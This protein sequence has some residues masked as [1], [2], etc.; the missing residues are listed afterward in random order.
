VQHWT[1]ALGRVLQAGVG[2]MWDSQAARGEKEGRA[3]ANAAMAQALAADPN[4][5]QA[6]ISAFSGNPW[7]QEMG[8][9]LGGAV[10]KSRFG[11]T[12]KTAKE[13]DF[14]TAKAGGYKGSFVEFLQMDKPGTVVNI[15]NK[16][17]SEEAKA[18]GKGAGEAANKVRDRAD[19]AMTNLQRIGTMTALQG[20]FETGPLAEAKMNV[21]QW[22]K[23]LGVSEATLE[24]WGIGKD[25]VGDA[26][27]FRGQANRGVVDM[28]GAGGFPANN[29]SDADRAFLTTTVPQLANDPRGNK[30]LMEFAK[31]VAHR[32]IEK[33][34]AWT[35]FRRMPE[36]KGKGYDDFNDTWADKVQEEDISGDLVKEAQA[37][38][39]SPAT[40]A[41]PSTGAIPPAAV[42][43]LKKAPTPEMRAK[44]DEVFGPGAADKALGAM[45]GR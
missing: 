32:D 21:G 41:T 36:N 20:K 1:Q 39:A 8:Q 5:P 2:S 40:A 44:F 6:A 17:D 13:R 30:L 29:F 35:A 45:N 33:Q 25:F 16:Q 26:Q 23:A 34:R 4:N 43:M 3:S 28:I 7:T 10:L 27:A 19:A 37:I 42:E 22:A 15:D 11:G 31:R 18:I 12:E 9:A 38:L 24:A 14:A